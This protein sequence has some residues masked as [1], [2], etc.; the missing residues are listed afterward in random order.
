M[1]DN[2]K[3]AGYSDREYLCW[4]VK[5]DKGSLAFVLIMCIAWIGTWIV[6]LFIDDYGTNLLAKRLFPFFSVYCLPYNHYILYIIYF[7]PLDKMLL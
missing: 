1:E 3:Y 2:R 5:K 4:F 7:N 6:S